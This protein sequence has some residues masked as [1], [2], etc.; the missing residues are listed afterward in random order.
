M[1]AFVGTNEDRV[2]LPARKLLKSAAV[3]LALLF[4]MLRPVCEAFAAPGHQH[5]AGV[6]AHTALQSVAPAGGYDDDEFCCASAYAQA[7][8]VPVT[9][10]LL[11]I[12]HGV[13]AAPYIATLKSAVDV[14]LQLNVLAR[15]D[16]APPLPFH[17]RSLRRLD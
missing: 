14:A 2:A 10:P 13:L 6:S 11:T 5:A 12:P 15:R 16:P 8:T 9:P 3:V 1:I 4:V 7:L 17:A